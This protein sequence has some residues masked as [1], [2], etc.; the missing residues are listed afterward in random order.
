MQWRPLYPHSVVLLLY[1]L[2]YR[3]EPVNQHP[4]G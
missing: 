2:K 1:V 4:R 3:D